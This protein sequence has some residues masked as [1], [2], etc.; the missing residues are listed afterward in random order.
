MSELL[1]LL[2]RVI[3]DV[4]AGRAVAVCAVVQTRGSTP[5]QPGACMMVR[6]DGETE[7]TL[8]GGCVEAEV[9]RRAF[10]YLNKR[11]SALLD[12]A[13][14]HDYG[15]DDGLIC[16]GQMDVAVMP[17]CAIGKLVPFDAAIAELE[18]HR[19]GVLPIVVRERDK[20]K[21]IEFRLHLERRPTLLI[22]GGGHVG[23]AVAR[24]AV[25]LDF[26]VVVIDDREKFADPQR[27]G[28][29]VECRVGRIDEVLRQY[30]IDPSCYVVVVTR[31]HQHD[32]QA[33][34][35]VIDSLARY[36]GMIGSR[37]KIK[38]IFDGL[39]GRGVAPELLERVRSP[40]GLPIKAA[41]VNEIGISIVAELIQ[42]RRAE[43]GKMVEGPFPVDEGIAD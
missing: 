42:V 32:E 17:V 26:H 19:E 16:G 23:L 1:P 40:I 36:V 13:L 31:G 43:Q 34:A 21:Q 41:T 12:F 39:I 27:F 28:P 2:K 3:E 15:W 38:A 22:A 33:L 10:D 30:P 20:P 8:G 14:D 6:N 18:A 4:R 37:R 35:A 9:R 7:G 29:D 24:L 11:E 5:Q 25:P